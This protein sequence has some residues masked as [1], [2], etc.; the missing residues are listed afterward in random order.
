MFGESEYDP[1][2][3]YTSI[4]LEE[5]F[6]ALVDARDAGKIVEFGVSNETP[7][8]LMRF[9]EIGKQVSTIRLYEE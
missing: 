8:G 6:Q 9:T 3:S 1:S 2:Q 4:S 7:Y 5:Q